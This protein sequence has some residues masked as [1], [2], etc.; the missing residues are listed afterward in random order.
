MSEL[1]NALLDSWD[2]Q[3][4]ILTNVVNLIEPDWLGFKIADGE[5]SIVNHLGH[6]HQVRSFFLSNIAPNHMDGIEKVAADGWSS[7][8]DIDK[9]KEQLPI[10]ARQIRTAMNELLDEGKPVGFYDHPVL[11]LQHMMWHEGWHVGAIMAALR[12]NGHDMPEEWE[13]PNIWAHWRTES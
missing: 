3:N 7:S 13:E 11:Y 8:T 4:A 6:I 9:I 10:S 2:R 5:L 12:L 1:K